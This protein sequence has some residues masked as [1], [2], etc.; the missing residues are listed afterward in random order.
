MKERINPR[1]VEKNTG[2]KSIRK[3]KS[4]RIKSARD[5]MTVASPPN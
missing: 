2:E 3:I 5:L 1:E 4:L